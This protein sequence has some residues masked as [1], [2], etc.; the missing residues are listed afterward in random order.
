M[1]KKINLSKVGSF[2][3]I[4]K[5]EQIW[6]IDDLLKKADIN[7]DEL[8]YLLSILSDIYSKNGEYFFDFDIDIESNKISFNNAT[9]I[10]DM[11]TLTDLE[12]FKVYTLINTINLDLDFDTVTKQDINSF[13]NILKEAFKIYDLENENDTDSKNI[14]LNSI[15]TIEYIKLGNSESD[16]YKIEPLLITSNTE[17]S[18][19]EALDLHDNKVKTFLINRIISIG[20]DIS[21]KSKREKN[22]NEI[23]VIFNVKDDS[24]L[25]KIKEF[26]KQETNYVAKFRNKNIAVEFFIENFTS[27]NV[28]SPDAVKV[29]VMN[30]V[31]SIR[32]LLSK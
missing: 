21:K 24:F 28:I 22:Q 14:N 10:N 11:E 15:T 26:E 9:A 23:E 27:A 3:S 25:L 5:T 13:N 16:F 32:E 19:L 6:N 30:R 8:L 12:L 1:V 18:V 2:I 4:I 7:Y 31:K 29:D 17:G 20:E